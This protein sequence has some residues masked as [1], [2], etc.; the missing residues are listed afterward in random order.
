M[1]KKIIKIAARLRHLGADD[2][3]EMV[4]AAMIP[5]EPG[6]GE[7]RERSRGVDPRHMPKGKREQAEVPLEEI[8]GLLKRTNIR[9]VV[10]SLRDF[11]LTDKQELAL[12]EAHYDG[13]NWVRLARKYRITV[14]DV[15]D[16]V[17]AYTRDLPRL[18]MVR[19]LQ[20]VHEQKRRRRG[21]S[22]KQEMEIANMYARGDSVREIADLL[23]IE[24]NDVI[25]VLEEKGVRK[26]QLHEF[27]KY[28]GRR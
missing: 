19:Q 7:P 25:S 8:K 16:I 24:L 17:Q 21:L 28:P 14:D 26:R 20:R 4:E 27:P 9:R 13:A 10:K 6:D 5:N 12:L 15:S 1:D 18:F 22:P 3:A 23:D 11:G 2:V